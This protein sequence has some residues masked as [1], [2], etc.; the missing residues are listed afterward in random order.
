MC[1][2]KH[3]THLFKNIMNPYFE[4]NNLKIYNC[5]C[6]DF[7]YK[8]QEK[9]DCILTSPPYN[10]CRPNNSEKALKNHDARYDSY[11]DNKTSEE[12]IEW[13]IDLFNNFDKVL[14]NNGVILYN[15]SY[16]SDSSN[17]KNKKTIGMLW[18]VI[19]KIIEK[20]NFIVADKIVWKKATAI[21]NNFSKNKL[22]RIT[23]DIFVF[24]RKDEYTSFN[25]NKKSVGKSKA[26]QPVY[27]NIYNF[28]EAKNNDGVCP[29]NKATYSTEL[30]E[31]LLKIYCKEGNHILDPFNG[32]GTTGIACRNLNMKYTGVEIS[33]EQCE[34]TKNRVLNNVIVKSDKL[35]IIQQNLL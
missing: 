30:C 15:I 35:E 14:E 22:T 3:I 26:G 28:I 13:S 4:D 9:F 32:T 6:F 17:S 5:D 25:C 19:S 1:Y 2:K 34:Y 16:G 18:L 23:E 31:K 12:Y 10:T 24:S 33:R 11:L 20:T 8:T 27:E 21:P 29:I 7:F